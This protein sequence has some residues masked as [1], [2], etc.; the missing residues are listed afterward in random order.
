ML[1]EFK[2]VLSDS[3]GHRRMDTV[4]TL[5][6][7]SLTRP[8][9]ASLPL[10]YLLLPLHFLLLKPLH[11]PAALLLLQCATPACPKNKHTIQSNRKRKTRVTSS[12][13]AAKNSPLLHHEMMT[14]MIWRPS[15]AA[16]LPRCSVPA[17]LWAE[18]AASVCVCV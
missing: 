13:P 16:L 5:C 2:L 8:H 6:P 11:P 12:L 9:S 10:L 1:R 14:I 3:H 15:L 7:S 4:C 18:D 17:S